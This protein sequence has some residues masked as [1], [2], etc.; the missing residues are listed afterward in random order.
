MVADDLSLLN[1][2]FHTLVKLLPVLLCMILVRVLIH[3]YEMSDL[4]SSV[5]VIS[6]AS[7]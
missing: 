2:A 3:F 6:V 7:S 1:R 4:L 5:I